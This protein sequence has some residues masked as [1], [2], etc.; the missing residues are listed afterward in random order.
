MFEC[1]KSVEPAGSNFV[2]TKTFQTIAETKS[3]PA[4]GQDLAKKILRF[5]I[6]FL[7]H[8][9]RGSCDFFIRS[10]IES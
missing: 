3:H 10:L 7:A 8:L 1:L 2:I 6:K 5:D 9:D 4:F